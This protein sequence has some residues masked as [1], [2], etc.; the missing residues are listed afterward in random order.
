MTMKIA[1]AIA[2]SAALLGG[3]ASVPDVAYSYYPA[4]ASGVAK[5]GQSVA[6][7]TDKTALIVV[8]TPD[9]TTQYSAD[10]SG[11]PFTIR[12]DER[13][14]DL[15]DNS[16]T[17]SF[18]EDGRLKT[19]NAES[20]GQGEA[21][22]KSAISL[23]GAVAP[24]GGGGGG[25][26][27]VPLRECEVIAQWG[28]GE[29]VSL[30]YQAPIDFASDER[31]NLDP[32]ADSKP[33]YELIKARLPRLQ[34]QVESRSEP[35]AGASYERPEDKNKYVFV[36]LRKVRTARVKLTANGQ[37][38]W[39]GNAIV[40]TTGPGGDYSLPIPKAALFGKQ[41]FALTLNAAGAIETVTYGKTTGA[42]AAVNVLTAAATAAAPETAS[43]R[44]AELKAEADEIVQRQRLARCR[45]QP[46]QCQ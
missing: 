31:I 46:D 43:A 26:A 17:V 3:C 44:A 6:C 24:L 10:T 40:P 11:K 1:G 27:V 38:L 15:A 9:V 5:V 2:G 12:F 21:F 7:T 13:R 14:A 29:P 34:A 35:W 41:S 19:I 37:A 20:T 33:L 23:I 28:A 45:A 22:L 39:V 32:T 18:Y 16:A 30:N 8:N 36:K 4:Q 25:S 42:G